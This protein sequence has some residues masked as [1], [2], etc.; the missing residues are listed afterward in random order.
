ME[1]YGVIYKV[2]NLVNNKIYIGQTTQRLEIRKNQH[3]SDSDRQNFN[4]PFHRAIRKYGTDIFEWKI[5]DYANDKESLNNKE[6]YWISFYDSIDRQKGYNVTIGG[7]AFG[8]SGKNNFWHGKKHS[9]EHNIKISNSLKK[10][11]KE[12]GS[13]RSR[14]VIQLALDGQ[15]IKEYESSTDAEIAIVEKKAKSINR[16]C[17][18]G[19]LSAYG[20]L[21]MHKDDYNDNNVKDLVERYNDSKNT[22]KAVVQLSLNG[23]YIKEFFSIQDAILEVG[24]SDSNLTACC[25]GRQKT[26]MGFRWMY[27]KDY[28]ILGE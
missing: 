2:T 26:H 21:W 14:K 20:F 12:N 18:G 4:M 8:G 27:K 5:I 11:R 7:D 19:Q 25:K 28:N 1:E 15:F 22:T 16:C 6:K 3:Y 13:P 9:E 23:E 17:N 10:A 24:G